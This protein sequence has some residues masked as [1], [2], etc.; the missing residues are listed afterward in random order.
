LG[1]EG[2]VEDPN[3]VGFALREVEVALAYGAEKFQ[4]FAFHAVEGSGTAGFDALEAGFRVKVKEQGAVGPNV[5]G[6]DLVDSGDV[7][8]IKGAGHALING[9][10]IEVTVAK[11]DFTLGE[12][13]LD[14]FAGELGAA[15]GKEEEFGLRAHI[16]TGGVVLDEGA[17][18][19]TEGSSAGFAGLQYLMAISF[20]VF[21][22]GADLG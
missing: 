1:I 21:G 16:L 22:K 18:G 4:G 19:F 17:E 6:R 13:G 12:G 20:E 5:T 11:D 15:G 14:D 8:G 9:G 2:S 10:G 7:G 3:A